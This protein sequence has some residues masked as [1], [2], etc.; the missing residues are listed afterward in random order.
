[1]TD[2]EIIVAVVQAF[3]PLP[4]LVFEIPKEDLDWSL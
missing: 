1:M 2:P 4:I 3:F